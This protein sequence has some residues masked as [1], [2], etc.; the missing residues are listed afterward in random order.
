MRFTKATTTCLSHWNT[1]LWI[2]IT[3]WC[4][5][6]D[7]IKIRSRWACTI[8]LK[9]PKSFIYRS[10]IWWLNRWLS[11]VLPTQTTCHNTK[12]GLIKIHFILTISCIII[13][14]ELFITKRLFWPFS[15]TSIYNIAWTWLAWIIKSI[16]ATIF[17]Q[18]VRQKPFFWNTS[19][20]Q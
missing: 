3:N 13:M 11:L 14:R 2:W 1:R 9:T 8:F 15:T 4:T 12:T 7:F 19:T 17:K 6:T 16:C 20:I 10:N 5:I 18:L